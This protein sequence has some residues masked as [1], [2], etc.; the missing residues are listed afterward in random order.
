[1]TN[2]HRKSPK[3]KKKEKVDGRG[4]FYRPNGSYLEEEL[5]IKIYRNIYT[6]TLGFF[7]FS[8]LIKKI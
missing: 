2:K 8:S 6:Q 4:H 3:K 7:C 5:C 1:M